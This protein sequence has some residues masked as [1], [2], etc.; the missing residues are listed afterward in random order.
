MAAQLSAGITQTQ[1]QIERA[2]ALVDDLRGQAARIDRHCRT[3]KLSVAT[4]ERNVAAVAEELK[5]A[6][7]A[8]ER[9][10]ARAH[11][12]AATAQG[13]DAEKVR[14]ERMTELRAAVASRIGKA[15]A[16]VGA[17]RAAWTAVFASTWVTPDDPE[18][19]AVMPVLRADMVDGGWDGRDGYPTGAPARRVP[20]ALGVRGTEQMDRDPGARP[21]QHEGGVEGP[22]EGA[23]HA[24]PG[25]PRA[26]S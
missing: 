4:Y 13:L 5:A 25:Y 17:L 22:D 15:S 23:R 14:L 2:S 12:L 11:D 7:V 19:F 9:L 20:I 10:V 24:D 16:E 3:G 6:E 18:G 8:H 21:D 26:T 1:T